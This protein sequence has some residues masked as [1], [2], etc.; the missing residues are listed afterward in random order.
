M[1]IGRTDTSWFWPGISGPGV[2]TRRR[3]W[4][5]TASVA[6]LFTLHVQN[7]TTWDRCSIAMLEY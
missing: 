1:G 3:T 7:L 2:L 6:L 5:R 4:L